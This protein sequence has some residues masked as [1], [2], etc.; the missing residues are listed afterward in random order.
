MHSKYDSWLYLFIT[1]PLMKLAARVNWDKLRKLITGQSY[2][3]QFHDWGIIAQQLER[4]YF[5]ILTRRASHLSTYLVALGHLLKTGKLSFWSHVLGNVEADRVPFKLIEATA[6]G[7]DYAYF[8]EV[9]MCDS[10]CI[11]KPKHY[12][13]GELSR[14]IDFLLDDIGKPYDDLFDLLDDKRMSC[15]E[16]WRGALMGLPDYSTRMANFEATI[17]RYGNLTPQMFYDC[18][19]FERV[20]EIRR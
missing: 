20:L 15:V 18:P 14:M 10:V 5:I 1:R 6:K 17:K 3:L 16:V 2:S 7:V 13:T 12:S 4:G 11:L 19:D 8:S 9:F